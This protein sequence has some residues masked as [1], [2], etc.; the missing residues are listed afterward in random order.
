MNVKCHNCK[1]TFYIFSDF[2]K[3]DADI[4]C[5]YCNAFLPNKY[6]PYVENAFNSLRE[7]N[8]K[9]RS[10]HADERCDLFEFSIEEVFVPIE[11]FKYSESE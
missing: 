7:L 5:P 1:N 9:V 10:K 11:K 4:R 3:S 6:T 8:Y 2:F